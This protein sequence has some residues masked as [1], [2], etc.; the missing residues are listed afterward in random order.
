LNRTTYLKQEVEKHLSI[1]KRNFERLR[2]ILPITAEDVEKLT[3]SDEGLKVMDQIAYR[4]IKLQDTLG[5]LIRSYLTEKGEE[6]EQ[7]S[8]IDLV[9]ILEK[10]GFPV[11]ESLWLKMRTLRNILTHEYPETKEQIAQALNELY[12]LIDKVEKFLKELK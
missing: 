6:V 3:S 7:L 9:N 4:Y 12:K 11:S 1:L 8:T 5:K 2:E 10:R